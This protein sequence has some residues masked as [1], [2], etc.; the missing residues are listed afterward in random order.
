MPAQVSSSRTRTWQEEADM[1]LS[2]LNCLVPE[3]EAV[4]ASSEFFTGKRFY[5]L[6]LENEVRTPEELEKKLGPEYKNAILT[7]NKE[8]GV[9]FARRLR[10]LG[11]KFVL[12]PVAF[13]A[14][15]TDLSRNWSGNE[16]MALWDLVITKKCQIVY[17]NEFWQFSDSCVFHYIA[18]LKS[19]K[20]LLDH[21]G[22]FLVLDGARKMVLSATRRLE[23]Y[24][25]DVPNLHE[26]LSELKA[27]SSLG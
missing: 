13:H 9:S 5:D 14:S 23:D 21:A 25:F 7:K 4:F 15:P 17:L 6:C 8:H 26:A 10:E 3:R 27:F 22:N 2:L 20:K 18:G 1:L 16:Y 11:H 19:G 12:T 24:G